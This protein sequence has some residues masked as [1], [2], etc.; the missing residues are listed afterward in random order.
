[1]WELTHDTSNIH[2]VHPTQKPVELFVRPILNH[3]REGEL[4]YEP[5]AGSGSQYMAA[6]QLNRRCAGIEL[7]PGYVDVICRRYETAFGEPAVLESTGQTFK[8][9]SDG[10]A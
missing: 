4:I 10:Q 9:L 1:M 8:E 7:A 3:T 2:R 6:Q 5:F